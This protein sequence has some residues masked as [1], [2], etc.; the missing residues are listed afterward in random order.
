MP[1]LRARCPEYDRRLGEY[2]TAVKAYASARLG[3]RQPWGVAG[4]E[5]P[6]EKLAVCN[7][8]REALEQH[9]QEHGCNPVVA[10]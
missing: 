6:A 5:D 1:R 4:A 7:R 8:A 9:H 10:P 3:A 2:F